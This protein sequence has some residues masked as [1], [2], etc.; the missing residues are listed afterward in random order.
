MC[1]RLSGEIALVVEVR[2]FAL[3]LTDL[4]R[5]VPKA[6]QSD[7]S[8]ALLFAVPSIRKADQSNIED[9]VRDEWASGLNVHFQNIRDLAQMAFS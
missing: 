8:S 9:T 2:D 7:Q 3:R 1:Y 6:K 4:R 5:S